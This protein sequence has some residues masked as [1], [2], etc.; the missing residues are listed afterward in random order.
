MILYTLLCGNLPF[1]DDNIPDLFRKI[2]NADY[3]FPSHI[4]EEPR[5]L[6]SRML[7]VDPLRRMTINEIR[8]HPW[9]VAEVPHYIAMPQLLPS[10][11]VGETPQIDEGALSRMVQLQFDEAEV[12]AAVT[13]GEVNKT[14]IAYNLVLDEQNRKKQAESSAMLIPAA[15]A[16]AA[17]PI[18]LSEGGAGFAGSVDSASS[19][20][21]GSLSGS[22]TTGGFGGLASFADRSD[23]T[24]NTHAEY[25]PGGEL[26]KIPKAPLPSWTIGLA[27]DKNA[28][29]AMSL[30]YESLLQTQV[31][32]KRVGPYRLEC[33]YA[34]LGGKSLLDEADKMVTFRLQLYKNEAGHLVDLVRVKGA[35]C[36]FMHVAGAMESLLR[37]PIG[38]P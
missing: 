33:V 22:L 27:V 28:S 18:K 12:V 11:D 1:D 32:W 36:A 25:T 20:Y 7:E 9:F 38:E 16:V 5:D 21:S 30:I 29:E 13:N 15:A 35:L 37:K 17:Q 14:T 19:G 8:R 31:R 26:S 34:S 10:V 24:T 6:I 4:T 23:I 3:T 2:K